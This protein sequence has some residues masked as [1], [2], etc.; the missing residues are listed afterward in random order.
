[1]PRV[2]QVI[3]SDIRRGKGTEESEVRLVRQFHSVEGDLLA[4]RDPLAYDVRDR[5]LALL[6][7]PWPVDH[8]VLLLASK[9]ARLLEE[10]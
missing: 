4:E 2:I 9:L 7:E 3:E 6:R 5:L 10:I 1:M 8:P